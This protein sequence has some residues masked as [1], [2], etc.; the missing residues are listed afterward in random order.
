[1]TSGAPPADPFVGLRAFEADEWDRFFGRA[2]WTKIVVGNLVASRLTLLYGESGVGKTSLL[3][4]GVEHQLRE[5][6]SNGDPRPRRSQLVPVVFRAWQ[7]DPVKPLIEKVWAAA[8]VGGPAPDSL[9]DALGKVARER[10]A[11]VVLILDQFEEYLLYHGHREGPGSL[12]SELARVLETP[13]L[14]AT[15]VISI[16]ED[17]L[18]RLDSL[19]RAIPRL[20]DNLLHLEPVDRPTAPRRSPARSSGTTA[21]APSDERVVI[22]QPLVDRILGEVSGDGEARTASRRS[23]SPTCS[24]CWSAS[25]RKRMQGGRPGLAPRC[26]IAGRAA[27]RR[28]SAT[29]YGRR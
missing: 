18:S 12:P 27:P 19:K 28:S 10:E 11:R 3:Q 29:T 25:G 4:A 1:M 9:S 16:R 23:S 20:F 8:A 15:V 21:S 24:S 7:G 14:P 6:A 22:E 17:A 5:A 2:T 26:S 13:R